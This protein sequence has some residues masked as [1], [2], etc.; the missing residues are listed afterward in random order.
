MFDTARR[1]VNTRFF[2][3]ALCWK[4]YFFY[5]N[6]FLFF[7]NIIIIFWEQ[8]ALLELCGW[9]TIVGEKRNLTNSS[10]VC[11]GLIMG[12]VDDIQRRTGALIS[13]M[14][15]CLFFFFSFMS[16]RVYSPLLGSW[17]VELNGYLSCEWWRPEPIWEWMPLL[18][19][20]NKRD[21]GVLR[22]IGSCSVPPYPVKPGSSP[23]V[24]LI[25][26]PRPIHTSA[27]SSLLWRF[28]SNSSA[29]QM[30]E[31]RELQ[32]KSCLQTGLDMQYGNITWTL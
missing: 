3:K 21:P 11:L 10:C 4:W 31:V 29:P 2:H 28:G 27:E 16:R 24:T 18:Q 6:F 1:Q 26:H 5:S 7:F 9:Q 17:L 20:Q 32:I 12:A 8:F 13:G 30:V 19:R 23:R 25:P 22:G 14:S 15:H